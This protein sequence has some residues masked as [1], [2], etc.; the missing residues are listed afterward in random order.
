MPENS[1]W[2]SERGTELKNLVEWLLGRKEQSARERSIVLVLKYEDKTIGRLSFEDGS[3]NFNY[4]PNFKATNLAPLVDF[5]DVDKAY[6][7]PVLFPFFQVRI[8]SL[9][10]GDLGEIVKR[11][12]LENNPTDLEILSRLG[13]HSSS[14]P[15]VLEVE[16]K[17]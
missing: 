10:R 16:S 14:D 5:P 15:Y 11:L 12:H 6:R 8:P 4:D 9:K 17:S 7:S 13:A 1:D 3:Y 2:T